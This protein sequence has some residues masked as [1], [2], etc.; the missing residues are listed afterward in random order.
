MQ[1]HVTAVVDRPATVAP[2]QP[3]ERRQRSCPH[4]VP[5]VGGLH[6]RLEGS[7]PTQGA[8]REG[9]DRFRDCEP[10]RDDPGSVTEN[11]PD[12]T[13]R[14][15]RCGCRRRPGLAFRI[16]VPAGGAYVLCA[17]QSR[18][19]TLPA[20]AQTGHRHS[21]VR[22]DSHDAVAVRLFLQGE[23][24]LPTGVDD[25]L[26]AGRRGRAGHPLRPR[27]ELSGRVRQVCDTAAALGWSW[28][29]WDRTVP[30]GVPAEHGVTLRR[31]VRNQ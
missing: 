8:E 7:S 16:G 5:D 20:W 29:G 14:T 10:P 9:Q 28:H 21:P 25:R 15:C 23:S 27:I 30:R 6:D 17:K 11:S 1:E 26:V 31:D 3:A 18:D 12:D 19:G 13:H 2:P 4:P 22:R 24:R